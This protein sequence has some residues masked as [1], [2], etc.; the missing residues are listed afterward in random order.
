MAGTGGTVTALVASSG[1][2]AV[3]T[4]VPVS[5]LEQPATTPASSTEEAA[6]AVVLPEEWRNRRVA[7]VL[8]TYN[9]ADN[10]PIIL[11]ALFALPLPQL[12]VYV[13]DDNSP[14]G[15][16]DL[17][18]KLAIQYNRLGS[19][20]LEVVRRPGK[21]GLGRAYVDGMG[22]A[23]AGGAEF[24]VQMDSDLSHNPKHLPEMLGTLLSTRAGVVIGSRYTASGSLD[25]SWGIHRKLLS[26]WA[27]FYV[28]LI[29]GLRV[30]D[31][32]AGFKMWHRD[33][34]LGIDL[35]AVGSSGYSFQVEMNYRALRHGVTIL[36]IPIHFTERQHGTS[37]MSFGTQL[38][39]A[40]LPIRLRLRADK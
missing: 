15:T 28:H 2:T 32:T 4:E 11:E 29:L 27:N 3:E 1:P 39:S 16:G 30:Q 19:D 18:E 22:R 26:A 7:V 35:S 21:E 24:V 5:A 13:V 38:E 17:A 8:P 40:L 25:A 23:L 12:K 34:L 31:V 37:K 14:D 33:A 36:E 9:E 20:R 10:L 6:A